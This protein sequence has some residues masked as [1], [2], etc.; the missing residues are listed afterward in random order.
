MTVTMHP[1]I[2]VKNFKGSSIGGILN[3]MARNE[4]LISVLKLQEKFSKILVLN[5]NQNKRAVILKRCNSVAP[6]VELRKFHMNQQIKTYFI[7][8]HCPPSETGAQVGKKSLQTLPISC[9]EIFETTVKY[10]R[11]STRH[12]TRRSTRRSTRH[13][14]LSLLISITQKYNTILQLFSPFI[15]NQK[16]L[17]H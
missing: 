4:Y 15:K 5:R 17:K 16:I 12:S 3:E 14:I 9:F 1:L 13:S 10:A 7:R 8:I 11:H 6:F 2:L